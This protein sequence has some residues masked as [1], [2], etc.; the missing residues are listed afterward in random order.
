M[1]IASVSFLG[2]RPCCICG[3]ESNNQIIMSVLMKLSFALE[4]LNAILNLVLLNLTRL[5]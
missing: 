5:I 2:Y 4:L 3:L 1:L